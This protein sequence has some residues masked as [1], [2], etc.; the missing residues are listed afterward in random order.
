MKNS[1]N[2]L[3]FMIEYMLSNIL[4]DREREI[5]HM[6][7]NDAN[8]ADISLLS[9]NG[10]SAR[11]MKDAG[12]A[13]RELGFD[14]FFALKSCELSD[15][16]SSDAEEIAYRQETFRDLEA[17]PEAVAVL[18]KAVPITADILSLRRLAADSMSEDY[19]GSV[20]EAELYVSLMELLRDG[21]LPLKDKMSGRAMTRLCERVSLLTESEKYKEVM[22]LLSELTSR[23]REIK[24]VTIGV[25]LDETLR[26]ESAGVL[27]VNNGKFRSGQTLEKILRLDFKPSE[28]TCIAPL[29][30]Y[31]KAMSDGERSAMSY[32]LNSGIS[33]VFKSNFR[34]WKRIVQT[35]V[36]ENTDFLI[37]LLPEIEFVSKACD[38]ISALRERGVTLSYPKIERENPAA[39]SAVGLVN[40]VVALKS[41]GEIVPNDFAFDEDAGAYIITGPNRGGKSVLTCAVGQ[42]ALMCALGMPV[43]AESAVISPADKVFCH[44]PGNSE[45]TINKGRLGEECQRLEEIVGKVTPRSIVLMDESL[46]STGS[47]EAGYIAEALLVGFCT[48]G[49]RTLFSTHLHSAASRLGEIN[50]KSAELGG[51][52]CDSL[53]A[54]IENGRR[55]FRLKREAPDGR[56][57]AGDVARKYGLTLEE[58]VEKI[59]KNR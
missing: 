27:S 19:L 11:R 39:F 42:A 28:L 45:D 21:L 12:R 26:P 35:Y 4:Y 8:C 25:N 5:K 18:K 50:K 57:Y 46:S 49:C 58:I 48:A 37:R 30:P 33:T 34:A 9:E 13:A 17:A 14:E 7:I 16:L 54:E 43:C 44:F 31:N 10:D 52:K 1:F 23:V 59:G 56:S 36:L 55:T 20:T 41:E 38:F 22:R 32:A 15:F 47:E 53:V 3:S 24:S 2:F 51:V 40:P 6:N 29:V